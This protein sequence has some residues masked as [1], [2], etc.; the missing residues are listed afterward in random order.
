MSVNNIYE[1]LERDEG[2]GP[3]KNGR[4]LPYPDTVGKL[5]IGYGRNLTDNGVSLEEAQVLLAHDVKV[6]EDSLT[7]ALPWTL[8]LDPIRRAVLVNMTFNMGI[9]SLT[10]FTRTLAFVKNHQWGEAGE[11]MLES[12]W[13]KQVGL[14]AVR[15]AVQMRTGE[16]Q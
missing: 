15:L 16:W 13:A 3:I 9:G 8:N 4:M 12:K 11:A 2:T 6:A 1:Q 14:R 10:L 7:K 5:T